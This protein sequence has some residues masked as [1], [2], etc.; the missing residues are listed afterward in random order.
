MTKIMVLSFNKLVK[1]LLLTSISVHYVLL[2][3]HQHLHVKQGDCICDLNGDRSKGNRC[4][5]VF[6][7][8]DS[9][10]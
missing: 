7:N 4:V 5:G 10:C 1:I 6:C 2:K 8:N 9:Q 3:E